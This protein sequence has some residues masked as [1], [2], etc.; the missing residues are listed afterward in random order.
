MYI[1]IDEVVKKSLQERGYQT[2]GHMYLPFLSYALSGLKELVFKGLGQFSVKTVVIDI[3][4]N[5]YVV[6][7]PMDFV[8]YSKVGA[9]GEDGKVWELTRN[10]QIPVGMPLDLCNLT[11]PASRLDPQIPTGIVGVVFQ[12]YMGAL[13]DMAYYDNGYIFGFGGGRNYAGEFNI[14]VEN[15]CIRFDPLNCRVNKV[16]L[17]YVFNP[18]ISGKDTKIPILAERALIQYIQYAS[19]RN[20]RNVALGEKQHFELMWKEARKDAVRQINHFTID[21]VRKTLHK[22]FMQTPKA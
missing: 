11:Y 1:T 14:D 6:D 8:R 4:T 21:E 20:R 12:N 15:G 13:D 10:P 2:D 16:V 17:E 18:E 3:D 9:I 19:I 5:R 22:N 7:L